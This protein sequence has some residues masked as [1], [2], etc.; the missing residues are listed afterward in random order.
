MGA[1]PDHGGIRVPELHRNP[2]AGRHR[3]PQVER[4][5]PRP[6]ARRRV[7]DHAGR[8]GRQGGVGRGPRRQARLLRRRD[9]AADGLCQALDAGTGK[10]SS[11]ATFQQGGHPYNEGKVV[12]MLVLDLCEVLGSEIPVHE[13]PEGS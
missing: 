7:G 6:G 11:T 12:L 3:Q 10:T 5:D 2:A 8:G 13:R 4:T 1:R 9:L